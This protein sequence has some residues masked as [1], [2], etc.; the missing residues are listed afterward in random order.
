MRIL[1]VE[2]DASIAAFVQ[3]GLVEEGHA[4]EH[5]LTRADAAE[6]QALAPA[7]VVLLDRRLPDGDGLQLVH[8]LREG[9]DRTP[10]VVLTARDAV[11]DRVE[12]LRAGAD[13]YLVKP[14]AFAELLARIDAVCRRARPGQGP[15]RFGPL[16]VDV[17]ALRVFCDGREVQLTATEFRLLRYLAEHAGQVC[18]RT[19]LLEA[20]WDTH[21][22]PGTN[23][24]DVYVS[25]L[26]AR[27]AEAGAPPLVHTVRGRGYVFELRD[28]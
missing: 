17:E 13:D 23:L 27:L 1:L 5:V 16:Q 21:H 8:R 2:D 3:Q 12:G 4:V 25:Y 24:V 7:D 6:R 10:V 18:T 26:R 20:V 22:D 11:D 28:R 19:R 14:F 15:L 9:G